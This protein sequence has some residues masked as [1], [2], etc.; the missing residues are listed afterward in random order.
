MA[1]VLSLFCVVMCVSCQDSERWAHIDNLNTIAYKNHYANLDTVSHYA[2]QA[3]EA[4]AEYDCGKA[5][6]LNNLAFVSI[7]KMNYDKAEEL[8]QEV[9]ATTDNQ[10]ELL[11]AD[12]QLMR[13]CQRK[14]QNRDFYLY[15]DRAQKYIARLEAE[16]QT[17]SQRDRQRLEY[18][19]SEYAIVFSAYLYYI[20]QMKQSHDALALIDEGG[21]IQK[22]TAQLLNYYYNVG[23]GGFFTASSPLKLAQIETDYLVR[24]IIMAKKAG[25]LYW[26]ANALQAFSEHLQ[27][28]T[29]NQH[30]IADNLPVMKFLNPE[31]VADTLLAG[32][33]AQRSVNTF[34]EFGDVYQTAGALRTLSQCYFNIQDYYSAIDCLNEALD[35]DTLINQ[36]AALVVSIHEQLS[37]D[38]SAVDDKANSD[39]SRNVYLDRQN[40][41]R[42]DR[43]LEARA[44][45]LDTAVT[46][47]NIT[48][49]IVIVSIIALVVL[50]IVFTRMRRRSERSISV[51]DLLQ[52]LKTWQENTAKAQESYDDEMEELEEQREMALMQAE[53]SL[54]QNIEQR[55]RMSLINSVT[56]F[57]DRMLVEVKN[58]CERQEPEDVRKERYEYIAELTRQ[59]NQYNQVLTDWIQLRKGEVSLRAESFPLQ[60]LFE[61]LKK[62]RQSFQLK[63][64]ELVVEDTA[65]WVKADRVLTLFMVNTL[66]DNARKFTPEGGVVRVFAEATP[67]YVEI[68]VAD[69]GQGMNEEQLAN[70]FSHQPNKKTQHGFGLM[71]CKGIIEK[72]RKISSVFSVCQITAE[73]QEGRGSTFRFRLPKGVVR[74][75]VGL[76]A[77]LTV[78]VDAGATGPADTVTTHADGIA[79]S[80]FFFNLQ[81]RY[82][83]AVAYADSVYAMLKGREKEP[84]N[85][86]I[87]LD[88]TN[89]AAIASLALHR[90]DLYQKYN[91]EYIELFRE[92]SADHNIGQYVSRMQSASSTR[93]IAIVILVLLLLTIFPAY[94]LLYYR[95][96]VYYHYLVNCVNS[97]NVILLSDATD[98]EKLARIRQLWTE[99]K[100]Y[101]Q[102]S[103]QAQQLDTLVNQICDALQR[104]IDSKALRETDI[105][106]ARDEINRI[107]YELERLHVNNN[108]LD[109]CFST[110]KHETMYFP[111]RILQLVEGPEEDLDALRELTGYYKELYTILSAQAQHQIRSLVHM[112][113]RLGLFL[114]RLLTRLGGGKAPQYL[115]SDLDSTYIKVRIPMAGMRLTEQQVVDLFTPA[116][117][118]LPCLVIRQ[119]VREIGETTNLRRSGIQAVQSPDGSTII[120][121]II[122]KNI[123]KS[124]KLS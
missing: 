21:E 107:N 27:D 53:R 97:V 25:L 123:W 82:A 2:H 42:Q 13:V 69:T 41:T 3:L 59:I 26:E 23:S 96:R 10:L 111:S 8:L 93:N 92:I 11:V 71:N 50:L 73:S 121:I 65:E 75:I 116:T 91:K 30:L 110:L 118:E 54:Q 29:V 98:E 9:A 32:N 22:D 103:Q 108:V 57:I 83:D 66:A 61:I 19:K 51:E 88:M 90:W 76:V 85:V 87:W 14:S 102:V 114:H 43:Y 100:Q 86:G 124:L 64:V 99:R 55:A 122:P 5:E 49:T 119:I 81:G 12:V 37:I 36:A 6:A 112:D 84:D 109:N 106:M 80:L 105:E 68:A 48:L 94:Y 62:G 38:Y 33:M 60:Q 104:N 40:D 101:T 20:G 70:V 63:G 115:V 44:A 74:I 18:A 117:I 24:C 67:D 47:L 1:F 35:R 46:Q 52:P 77:M 45:Q 113:S 16:R 95:H 7:M 15:Q 58:L 72:Y 34:A 120:E 28:T 89:E 31:N 39:A 4:S 56:P 78:S 79:D 17:L